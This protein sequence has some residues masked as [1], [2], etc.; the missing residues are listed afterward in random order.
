MKKK[1]RKKTEEGIRIECGKKRKARTVKEDVYETKN[2]LK[3]TTIKQ[4]KQ[5]L[6]TRMHMIR[7]PCNYK[8]S[9]RDRKC[10]LCGKEGEIKTEHYYECKQTEDIRRRW[11]TKVDDL[12]SEVTSEL[13]RTSE[14]LLKVA[15]K[16][17][18]KWDTFRKDE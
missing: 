12:K 13:I 7:M 3:E 16:L 1:I 5:I 11:N 6:Q 17:E 14:Y 18:P 4:S 9:E 8:Q 10:W 2:Y 15:D